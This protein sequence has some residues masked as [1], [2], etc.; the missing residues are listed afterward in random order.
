MRRHVLWDEVP[1]ETRMHSTH[2]R[3]RCDP[4]GRDVRVAPP[5]CPYGV[6]AAKDRPRHR[7]RMAWQPGDCWR[8]AGPRCTACGPTARSE[9][10]ARRALSWSLFALR[11]GVSGRARLIF[12]IV[13]YWGFTI[14]LLELDHPRKGLVL[15]LFMALLVGAIAART[16]D[17]TRSPRDEAGPGR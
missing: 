7:G 1:H 10:R 17:A 4:E 16:D 2:G 13:A 9:S 8:I 14:V 11:T 3:S 6:N 12:C 5:S 15:L